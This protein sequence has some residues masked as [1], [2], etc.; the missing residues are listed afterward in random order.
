MEGVIA[1]EAESGS[2]FA[3]GV[4]RQELPPDE[5]LAVASIFWAVIGPERCRI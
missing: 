5:F 3:H 4:L 1:A 2:L